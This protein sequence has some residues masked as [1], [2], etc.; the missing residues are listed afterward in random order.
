MSPPMT[1]VRTL[2]N[3]LSDDMISSLEFGPIDAKMD[4]AFTLRVAARILTQVM[5]I[6][7]VRG[8]HQPRRSSLSLF[9]VVQ[10]LSLNLD[11]RQIGLRRWPLHSRDSLMGLSGAVEQ[12]WAWSA[13]AT[14]LG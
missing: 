14:A 13:S 1:M 2:G 9:G 4:G 8:V 7:H 5:S 12:V 3:D 6:F 11:D 10:A